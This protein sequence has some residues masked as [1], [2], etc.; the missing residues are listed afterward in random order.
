MLLKTCR[1]RCSDRSQVGKGSANSSQYR[2]YLHGLMKLAGRVDG[3]SRVRILVVRY[4]SL[5]NVAGAA[6]GAG[7]SASHPILW[8]RREDAVLTPTLRNSA[9]GSKGKSSAARM[10][11]ST[12][13][14]RTDMPS[15]SVRMPRVIIS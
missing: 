11:H 8:D 7:T 4:E 3:A 9:A 1:L 14:W 2:K 13:S 10:I 15:A 12:G 5:V 6:I